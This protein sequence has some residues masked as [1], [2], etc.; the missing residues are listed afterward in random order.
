MPT[1]QKRLWTIGWEHL[2]TMSGK[3]KVALDINGPG[4]VLTPKGPQGVPIPGIG[5]NIMV[6]LENEELLDHP[7]YACHVPVEAQVPSDD[8][9][10]ELVTLVWRKC[11]ELND[12]ALA[13]PDETELFKAPDNP[14]PKTENHV[15]QRKPVGPRKQR[16][17]VSHFPSDP[18][19]GTFGGD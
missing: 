18:S 17:R 8:M 10:R 4:L 9:V 3:R 11:Q 6:S 16:E 15:A 19:K 14:A 12:K 1:Q 2:K 13:A 7:I 5:W